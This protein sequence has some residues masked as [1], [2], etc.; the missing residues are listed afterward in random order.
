MY[1]H[2]TQ[3]NRKLAIV[4]I[5]MYLISISGFIYLQI[6]EDM[7]GRDIWMILVNA[8]IVSI[9]LVLV[10]GAIYILITAWREH[11]STGQVNPRLAKII[12]WAPRVA[13]IMIIFFLTLFSLDVFDGSASWLEMLG[14]FIMHNIPSIILIV[15]LLFAWKRP[16][17][18]FWAFLIFGVGFSLFFVHDIQD[19]A[20]LLSLFVLPFLLI[21]GLFYIDWKWL[22]SRADESSL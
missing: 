13:S 20:N 9:P 16:L 22:R 17:V 8:L 6:Q 4:L 19:A 1:N 2:D 3:S 14:G 18:G 12:R 7:A 11:K 5:F 21:S 15:I 10:F